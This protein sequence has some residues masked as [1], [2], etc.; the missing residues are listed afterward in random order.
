VK[1]SQQAVPGW[2]DL[3]L[4]FGNE[5]LAVPPIPA[6]HRERIAKQSDWFWS[7]RSDVTASNMYLFQYVD[8]ILAGPVVEYSA[9]SQSGHG[10]NSYGL[11]VSIVKGPL[12]V[13]FQHSWGGAYNSPAMEA[14]ELSFCF[15]QMHL[16]LN[17]SPQ[18]VDGHGLAHLI[19]WSDFR[20]VAKYW[21]KDGN[22][23]W[24]RADNQL[25]RPRVRLNADKRR[26][27]DIDR[28][29]IDAACRR[30]L[31]NLTETAPSPS[32]RRKS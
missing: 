25:R 32:K 2:I 6:G 28:D 20:N 29:G 17:S 19:A 14:C 5:C 24:V 13:V 8:E 7:T 11:N 10:V 27:I 31:K 30:F 26:A 1:N 4:S 16:L 22:G 18:N 12:A 23:E 15:Y 21:I 9:V 3:C